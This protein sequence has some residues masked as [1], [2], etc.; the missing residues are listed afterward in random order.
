MFMTKY[1][2]TRAP[3]PPHSSTVVILKEQFF[4][5]VKGGI[6]WPVPPRLSQSDDVVLDLPGVHHQILDG[7]LQ[8]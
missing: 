2:M 6:Q 4:S 1:V 8:R 7:S 3:T 5:G